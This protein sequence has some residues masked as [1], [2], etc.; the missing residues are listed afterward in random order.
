MDQYELERQA[1]NR[2][3]GPV[4]SLRS[5]SF[6]RLVFVCV[7]AFARRAWSLFHVGRSTDVIWGSISIHFHH[8]THTPTA[9][10]AEQHERISST[11]KSTTNRHQILLRRP[12][13]TNHYNL[14]D[15]FLCS[16]YRRPCVL[17]FPSFCPCWPPLVYRRGLLRRSVAPLFL[18]G[19]RPDQPP[20]STWRW[21]TTTPSSLRSSSW[22]KA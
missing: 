17:F 7:C 5:M 9:P 16:E 22:C 11:S 21:T 12:P 8:K 4:I 10:H 14:N 3:T 19:N 2:P 15:S 1:Q 18:F 13:S 20:V 6:F